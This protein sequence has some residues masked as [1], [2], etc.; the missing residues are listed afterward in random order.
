[1]RKYDTSRHFLLRFFL[2]RKRQYGFCIPLFDYQPMLYSFTNNSRQHAISVRS[3][4]ELLTNQV[5]FIPNLHAKLLKYN[6]K[7]THVYLKRLCI[8]YS[9]TFTIAKNAR[10]FYRNLYNKYVPK[11]EKHIGDILIQVLI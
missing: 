1:M 4:Y 9:Q 10:Y 5:S 11:F 3:I 6:G 7:F 2:H 8:C